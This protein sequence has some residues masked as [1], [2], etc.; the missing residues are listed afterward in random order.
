MVY[1]TFPRI[2]NNHSWKISRK[3]A[4]VPQD[5]I[6]FLLSFRVKKSLFV[7]RRR[8]EMRF[9]RWTI[10]W[11]YFRAMK[12]PARIKITSEGNVSTIITC[13][14]R[15]GRNEITRHLSTN[16]ISFAESM[17]STRSISRTVLRY[18]EKEN[19]ICKREKERIIWIFFSRSNYS[20]FLRVFSHR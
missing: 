5:E 15:G 8:A 16:K 13:S 6:Y 4:H 14:R 1:E 11:K 18:I 20:Q 10:P 19:N 2:N 17:E 9:H 7:K 12:N 3:S